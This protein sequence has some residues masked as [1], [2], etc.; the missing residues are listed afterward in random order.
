MRQELEDLQEAVQDHLAVLKIIDSERGYDRTKALLRSEICN[1]VECYLDEKMIDFI[2]CVSW[3]EGY[4]V[5]IN[6]SEVDNTYLDLDDFESFNSNES[7][8]V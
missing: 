5:E 1:I 6:F 8:L 2:T 3:D 7:F 4:T